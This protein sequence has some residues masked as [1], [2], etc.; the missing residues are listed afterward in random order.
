MSRRGVEARPLRRANAEH[1]LYDPQTS[2][3]LLIAVAPE[4]HDVL[5]SELMHRD[6][7]AWTVGEVVTGEGLILAD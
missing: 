1:I 6:L 7:A 2:G 4:R 3:G 5:L